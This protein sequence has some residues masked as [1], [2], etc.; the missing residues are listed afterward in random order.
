MKKATTHTVMSK[1][2]CKV[3]NKPLKQ[4]LIDRNPDA[5]LCYKHWLITVRNKPI[6]AN[7]MNV[8]S[9]I[10]ERSKQKMISRKGK[11]ISR[12]LK[13]FGGLGVFLIMFIA[14]GCARDTIVVWTIDD[15]VGVAFICVFGSILLIWLLVTW[16]KDIIKK[17]RDGK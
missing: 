10:D 14:Y 7:K 13:A 12:Q 9:P 17:R 11:V 4:N 16:I 6:K 5:D 15:I 8:L 3:C 2:C 1:E